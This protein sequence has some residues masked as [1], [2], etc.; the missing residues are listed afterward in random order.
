MVKKLKS[1]LTPGTA[2]GEA[3]ALLAKAHPAQYAKAAKK[4]ETCSNRFAKACARYSKA[5]PEDRL[6]EGVEEHYLVRMA[7]AMPF[8]KPMP[9]YFHNAR[10]P[11]RFALNAVLEAD[12]MSAAVQAALEQARSQQ[13]SLLRSV[14]SLGRQDNLSDRF[15]EVLAWQQGRVVQNYRLLRPF[16]ALRQDQRRKALAA[17]GGGSAQVIPLVRPAQAERLPPLLPLRAALLA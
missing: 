17:S 1:T 3:F 11:F 14:R 8:G 6:P 5:H 10:W 15:K 9:L 13:A 2:A 16:D 7:Q 12:P 4:L